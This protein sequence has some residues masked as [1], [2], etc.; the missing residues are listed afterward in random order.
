ME[1]EAI[2]QMDSEL[3][4]LGS[5]LSRTLG[6]THVHVAQEGGADCVKQEVAG[7][8]RQAGRNVVAAGGGEEGTGGAK[9][10]RLMMSS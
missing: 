6:P 10:T 1:G 5:C 7:T 3:L 2:E 4:A 8:G 9:L